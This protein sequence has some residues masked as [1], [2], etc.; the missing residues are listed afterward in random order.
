MNESV[1]TVKA[2][3]GA[4]PDEGGVAIHVWA[5]HADRVF[6]MGSFSNGTRCRRK[7]RLVKR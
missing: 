4:I 7:R 1:H 2:L 5:P 3:M 6:V